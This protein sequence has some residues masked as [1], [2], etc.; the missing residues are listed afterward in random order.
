VRQASTGAK[1]AADINRDGEADVTDF[2]Q[3]IGEWGP[4]E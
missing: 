1:L 3:L 4:C 2:L